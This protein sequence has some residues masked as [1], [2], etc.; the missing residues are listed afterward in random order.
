MLYEI[1]YTTQNTYNSPASEGLWQFMVLPENNST[2]IV[3]S[4]SVSNSIGANNEESINGFGFKTVRISSKAAIN[5]FEFKLL[6]KVEK[7][8]INPFSNGDFPNLEEERQ[9]IQTIDFKVEHEAFLTDTPLTKIPEKFKSLFVFDEH[10]SLFDNIVALNKWSFDYF[11]FKTE[12]TSTDT[13][14]VEI[15]ENKQGVCQDF[16]HVVCGIAR[17]NHIP[18]R[19]IS[20]YLHQGLGLAGDSQMHAWVECFI[21]KLGWV[22]IDP[23][24]NLLV[25]HNHIKVSHGRDYQDCAPLRGIVHASGSSDHDTT[26]TVFVRRMG[27]KEESTE[28]QQQDTVGQSQAQGYQNVQQWQQQQQ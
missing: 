1:T 8:E 18:A 5:H 11:T 26:Y 2:Q 17:L 25:D 7:T 14:I 13:S 27:E 21:P 19:Y 23:T 12:V 9:T 24:N 16:T 20:G 3:E 4:Y 22:G 28:L 10:K 6:C 15:L